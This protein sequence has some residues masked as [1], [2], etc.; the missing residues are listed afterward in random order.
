MQIATVQMWAASQ[1]V[2]HQKRKRML[3]VMCCDVVELLEAS[4]EGENELQQ[5]QFTASAPALSWWWGP[6]SVR[7]V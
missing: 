4:L 1:R 2:D 5:L 6:F 3:L 7:Y